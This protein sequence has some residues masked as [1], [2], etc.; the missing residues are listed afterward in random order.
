M[1]NKLRTIFKRKL[2][3]SLSQRSLKLLSNMPNRLRTT[4]KTKLV[5][6]QWKMLQTLLKNML[7]KLRTSCKRRPQD[8]AQKI[9]SKKLRI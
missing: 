5:V 8:L 1:L 7:K 3:I 9:L 4:F 6:S 2:L